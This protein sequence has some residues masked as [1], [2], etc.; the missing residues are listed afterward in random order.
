MPAVRNSWRDMSA[1]YGVGVER[2]CNTPVPSRQTNP[3]ATSS[4]ALF[5]RCCGCTIE[6]MNTDFITYPE[7]APGA[8]T[9]LIF[10]KIYSY[11]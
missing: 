9:G 8:F 4:L 10:K 6:T 11:Q 5:S 3:A 1:S 7:V 2:L